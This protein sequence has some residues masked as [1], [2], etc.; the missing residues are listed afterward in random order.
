MATASLVNPDVGHHPSHTSGLVD[1]LLD[2]SAG[3]VVGA[4]QVDDLTVRPKVIEP[5]GP[6]VAHHEHVGAVAPDVVHLLLPRALREHLVDV[7]DRFQHRLAVLVVEQRGLVL[8]LVELVG[9]QA[10]DQAVAERAGAPEQ[11]DVPDVQDIEC[12]VG[13]HRLHAARSVAGGAATSRAA[14]RLR[15]RWT[16]RQALA[17][18]V[19]SK[20]RRVRHARAVASGSPSSRDSRA[21]DSWP[22]SLH[23]GPGNT[24]SRS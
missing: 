19:W 4:R 5:S 20:N 2:G 14:Y 6:V 3:Y 9:R 17:S 7:P 18:S 22:K 12:P 13:D 21:A 1:V 24:C 10:D 23:T 11:V 15:T 8:A 16:T